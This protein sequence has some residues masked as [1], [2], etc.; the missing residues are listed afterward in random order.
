M[1]SPPTSH[2]LN[3]PSIDRRRFVVSPFFSHLTE[4]SADRPHLPLASMHLAPLPRIPI[5]SSRTSF[6]LQIEGHRRLRWKMNFVES[7]DVIRC[8]NQGK[9]VGNDEGE[10][11]S[12]S[13]RGANV[14][15][16]VE[17]TKPWGFVSHR[18]RCTFG[19]VT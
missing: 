17:Q 7:V 14:K 13:E 16:K 8:R 4:R 3:E 2:L 10:R 19:R 15:N 9:S 5:V 1:L 11:E 12:E 6:E 18:D